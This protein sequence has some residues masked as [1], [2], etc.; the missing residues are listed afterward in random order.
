[1]RYFF[2]Y[3]WDIKFHHWDSGIQ[4]LVGK[5]SIIRSK[6]VNADFHVTWA[7]IFIWNIYQKLFQHYDHHARRADFG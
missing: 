3:K 2:D 7:L 4:F 1:M 5:I 6:L